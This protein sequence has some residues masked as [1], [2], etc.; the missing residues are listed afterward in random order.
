VHFEVSHWLV[1]QEHCTPELGN[2]TTPAQSVLRISTHFVMARPTA[3]SM[4]VP[5]NV[6]KRGDQGAKEMLEMKFPEEAE[7]LSKDKKKSA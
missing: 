3:C 2:R 4:Q 1:P 7:K 6:A 5:L